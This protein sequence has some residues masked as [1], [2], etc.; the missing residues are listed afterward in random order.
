MPKYVG[1]VLEYHGTRLDSGTGTDFSTYSGRF[2]FIK[3]SG[4]PVALLNAVIVVHRVIVEVRL[5]LRPHLLMQRLSNP[6]LLH[7]MVVKFNRKAICRPGVMRAQQLS[8]G[9]SL[10]FGDRWDEDSPEGILQILLHAGL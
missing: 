4:A 6:L 9:E 7:C 5:H 2:V 1:N 3:A 10:L 8:P